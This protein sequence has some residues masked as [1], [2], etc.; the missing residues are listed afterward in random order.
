MHKKNSTRVFLPYPK[1]QANTNNYSEFLSKFV[2][3]EASLR[4]GL[5]GSDPYEIKSRV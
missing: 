3:G 1:D 4:Y 2:T 5:P